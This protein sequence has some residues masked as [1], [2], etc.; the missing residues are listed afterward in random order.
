MK[1][2]R[3]KNYRTINSGKIWEAYFKAAKNDKLKEVY[4]YKKRPF[5]M[6]WSDGYEESHMCFEWGGKLYAVVSYDHYNGHISGFTDE[7]AIISM[8]VAEVV[9]EEI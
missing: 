3:L 4:V 5:A 2:L 8:R 7:S 6:H 1:V 9:E